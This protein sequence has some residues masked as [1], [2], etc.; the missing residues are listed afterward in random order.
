LGRAMMSVQTRVSHM[1]VRY[2]GKTLIFREFELEKQIHLNL[3][4]MHRLHEWVR[5]ELASS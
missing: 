3:K 5:D 4:L 1:H 2:S